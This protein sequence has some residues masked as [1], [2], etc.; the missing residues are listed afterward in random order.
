M[1]FLEFFEILTSPVD[2][3]EAVDIIL[4]DFVKAFVKVPL[5]VQLKGHGAR[6]RVLSW[7]SS[8]LTGRKHTSCAEQDK[9]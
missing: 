1:R 7:I 4:L 8:R 2:D 9:F 6:G 3:G 5:I